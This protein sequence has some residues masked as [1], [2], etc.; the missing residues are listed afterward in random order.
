[1]LAQNMFVFNNFVSFCF[2]VTKGWT[3]QSTVEIFSYETESWTLLDETLPFPIAFP[4]TLDGSTI[5]GGVTSGGMELD[6][7]LDFSLVGNLT[8]TLWP[9]K[10]ITPRSGHAA[11]FLQ[12]HHNG[13]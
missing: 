7:V 13:F 10:L 5:V 6:T 3:V 11:V 1:M 2:H 9:S 8:W 12:Q 4:A